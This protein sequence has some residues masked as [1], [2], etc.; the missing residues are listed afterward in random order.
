MKDIDFLV[1]GNAS[2]H[3]ILQV[4]N[5]PDDDTTIYIT[6]DKFDTLFYGG[7]GMN[8]VY[9]LSKL[10]G[11][12]AIVTSTDTGYGLVAIEALNKLGVNTEYCRIVEGKGTCYIVEDQKKRRLTILGGDFGKIPATEMPDEMFDRAKTVILSI[13]HKANVDKFIDK[14]IEKGL[15]FVLSM[16]SDRSIFTDEFI[17]KAAPSAG[18]IFCNEF[19]RTLIEG[20]LKLMDITDLF[21]QGKAEVICVTQGAKGAVVYEKG[22]DRKGVS[23][24]VTKPDRI[25]DCTGAGDGFVA[26]FMYGY[27]L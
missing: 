19:E 5:I 16:R 11:K 1:L 17:M 14:L 3:Y 25:L 26:G 10:G 24:E 2:S 7:T 12:N 20:V 9:S 18:M 13:D 27:Y 8:I 4:D 15:D 6:N 22:K 21:D 23:L